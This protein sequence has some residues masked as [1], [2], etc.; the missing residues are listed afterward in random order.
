MNKLIIALSAIAIL[1]AC[2]GDNRTL[3]AGGNLNQST[4]L[5]ANANLTAALGAA[6][7]NAQ[8][9]FPGTVGI[10]SLRPGRAVYDDCKTFTIGDDTTDAHH[11][12]EYDCIKVDDGLGGTK[13]LVGFYEIEYFDENQKD[14]E[15]GYK[16]SYDLTN[17][18]YPATGE[19]GVDTFKGYATAQI[20]DTQIIQEHDIEFHVIA[21]DAFVLDWG[22]RNTLKMTVTPDDMNNIYQ[23]GAVEFTGFYK[24]S[25]L[26]GG[27]Q[28]GVMIPEINVT[29]EIKSK[30]LTYDQAG[31]TAYYKTGTITMKDAQNTII[32]EYACNSATAYYNGTEFTWTF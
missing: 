16:V 12:I 26:L 3:A 31:C 10:P 5:L 8:P 24:I 27:D 21:K 19:P 2:A 32:F 1:G 13:S 7:L 6:R 4:L 22:F 20:T 15:G 9:T 25:G 14:L 29:Y 30:D 28:N 11:R 23:S 18:T 17:N